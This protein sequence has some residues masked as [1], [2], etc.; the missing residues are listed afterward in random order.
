[1]NEGVNMTEQEVTRANVISGICQGKITQ[2]NAAEVLGMSLRHI[3]RL[4]AS[5]LEHG[6][7][8][9]ISKQR[10]KSSNHRLPSIIKAR[11]LEL[12]TCE[13]YFGFWSH[14]NV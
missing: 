10:G 13:I 5:F 11:V 1:V 6:I 8:I 4:H 7:I 2:K 14:T 9:L 3:Q 12:V